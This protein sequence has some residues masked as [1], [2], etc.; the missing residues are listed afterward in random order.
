MEKSIIKNPA[1]VKAGKALVASGGRIVR[2]RWI[3][4]NSPVAQTLKPCKACP[5]RQGCGKFLKGARCYYQ[6]QNLKAEY[7]LQGALTSGDPIDLLKNIQSTIAKLESVIYY[8]ETVLGQQPNKNDIKE[9]AFLKLQIYEMVYGR[10]P[11]P[12]AVQVNAPTID[13]KK[14]M[15]EMRDDKKVVDVEYEVK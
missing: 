10:K 4:K 7:K 13:V 2:G 14:L 6:I 5:I 12:V 8:N 11:P 15:D 3:D 9:L 1:N